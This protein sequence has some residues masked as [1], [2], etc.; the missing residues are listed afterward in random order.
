MRIEHIAFLKYANVQPD[1]ERV[2]SLSGSRDRDQA[3]YLRYLKRPLFSGL[4]EWTLGLL[5]QGMEE[6]RPERIIFIIA[7]LHC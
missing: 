5:L 3:H 1:W 7:A 2:D 4:K 6:Q